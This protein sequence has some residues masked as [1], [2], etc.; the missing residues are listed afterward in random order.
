MFF[1][2]FARKSREVLKGCLL[3]DDDDEEGSVLL[4]LLLLVLLVLL[5]VA[6]WGGGKCVYI[7]IMFGSNVRRGN[8]GEGQRRSSALRSYSPAFYYFT[9]IMTIV[10][11]D[12]R[13]A[14]L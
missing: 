5:W 10:T 2:G 7:Y 12:R 8:G 6:L 1:R 13:L 11:R 4:F 3:L 9:T 14:L